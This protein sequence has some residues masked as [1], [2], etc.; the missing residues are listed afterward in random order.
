MLLRLVTCIGRFPPQIS[1]TVLLLQ[2]LSAIRQPLFIGHRRPPAQWY[3]IEIA[4]LSVSLM[5]RG[6]TREGDKPSMVGHGASA[7]FSSLNHN[8]AG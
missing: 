5:R 2:R 6:H 8:N 1:L 3:G 7:A 4:L